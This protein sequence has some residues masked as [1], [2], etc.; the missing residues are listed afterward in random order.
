M[1]TSLLSSSKFIAADRVIPKIRLAEIYL[2]RAEI[3][4]EQDIK[5]VNPIALSD[6]NVVRNRAGLPSL[7]E[8]D[9]FNSFA[10]YDSLIL[11]RKRELIYEG[12]LFHDLKRW[13]S[14]IGQ[15]VATAPKFILPIPQSETDT[16]T[17]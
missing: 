2:S 11:E 9:F 5:A 10:F 8:T 1:N 16:W 7:V 6:L 15:T 3:L 4:Y 12:V 13:K 14:K 17:N